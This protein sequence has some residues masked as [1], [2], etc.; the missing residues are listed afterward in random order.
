[1][2]TQTCLFMLPPIKW[3]FPLLMLPCILI[4]SS[5]HHHVWPLDDFLS[6]RS[7]SPGFLHTQLCPSDPNTHISFHQQ[8]KLFFRIPNPSVNGFLRIPFEPSEVTETECLLSSGHLSMTIIFLNTLRNVSGLTFLCKGY[9]TCSQCCSTLFWIILICLKIL[10]LSYAVT[11]FDA[12]PHSTSKSVFLFA[13]LNNMLNS[14]MA[15]LENIG[16][17]PQRLSVVKIINYLMTFLQCCTTTHR[18]YLRNKPCLLLDTDRILIVYLFWK[19]IPKVIQIKK[20]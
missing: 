13:P 16:Y 10:L 20:H 11:F 8:T 5:Y 14:I 19:A 3:R 17:L 1:M 2:F 12:L 6:P 7:S 15:S 9:L 4:P 18:Q